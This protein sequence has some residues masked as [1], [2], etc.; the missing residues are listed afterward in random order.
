MHR[1]LR[2]FLLRLVIFFV[3]FLISGAIGIL[4]Y[5]KITESSKSEHRL[6]VEK[7]EKM[8]KLALVRIAVKDVLTQT[9][10]R[11]LYLPNAKALVMVVGEVSAGIDLTKVKTEDIVD[12]ETQVTIKLPSPEILMSKINHEK[13]RVYDV[14]W[15]G[16]STVE[17]MDDAYKAADIDLLPARHAKLK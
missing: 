3:A 4:I 8:G 9:K 13:S 7:I 2:K 17:L 11:P 16:W 15:G 12:S 5:K 10:E 1:T 6:S 14:S